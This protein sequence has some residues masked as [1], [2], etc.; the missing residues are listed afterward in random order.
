MLFALIPILF[1]RIHSIYSNIRTIDDC[2]L[3]IVGGTTSALGAA[4]SASKILNTRTCLLEPTDWVGGQLTAEL[5]SAPD[6]AYHT[7]KD[8]D[9]NFTLD[10]GAIDGQLDNQNLLFAHM[11][12]VLGDTGRC[13]VSPKC[14]IPQLFHSQV[15]LPVISNVRI[16]YNTVIKRVAKDVTGRR[17]IQVDA[18][19]RTTNLISPHCRFLSEELS[20]WY[21]SDDTAWFNKTQ[22][23]FR[24][25]SFVIEGT[26]WGEV[27]VLSNASYI[28]GLMEQFDGDTSGVGNST[29]GQSFTFD[30]LEQLRETPV[31]ELPNPLPEPTGGANYSFESLTWERIWTYRRVNTSAPDSN[32]IAVHDLTI[33]NWAGGNDYRNQYFFLSPSDTRHQRDIDQWQGGL[34]LDAIKNAERLAYGYHYWY[35]KNAP[36]QWTNRTVLIRSVSAAGTCHGLAKMPY[37]RESRRSIGYQNF[38]MNITTISGHARDLHG[39]IFDDRLCVGAYNVDIHSMGQCTYPSYMHENYPILPYY[40]PLR[41]MTNRDVDN[42]IVIGKTMAQ[43]FLVNSATRLH[44]VEFSIGQAAGVVGTYAVQNSLQSVAE[45]LEEQHIKR[46]QTIVKQFTP[47]SW[48]INGTRYPDD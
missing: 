36:T 21:S 46:V 15:V 31:D 7:I 39:Y 6:F 14:S 42:L 20:D 1:M 32:T 16:F 23:S 22:L 34:N 17:I 19:Q 38:L 48:T 9:T 41:A 11:L 30:F 24:N 43:T 26:S 18:I 10:V 13:W 33:Q 3:L 29:C 40:I 28:Q 37:L 45:M 35:R 47:T 44:P 2:Q 25:V 12:N 5:L 27:L 8:K 4:L